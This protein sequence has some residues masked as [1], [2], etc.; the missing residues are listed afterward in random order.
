M[1]KIFASIFFLLLPVFLTGCQPIN[2]EGSFFASTFINPFSW[3]IHILADFTGGSFGIAIIS[4]TLLIR[5]ILMPL[6]MKQYNNQ[7]H[8]KEK[9][10]ALKPEMDQIQKKLKG[11]RD[12]AEQKKLQQEMFGLYQ[13]HGVNPL[14]GGCLPLLIQMPILMGLYDA[15]SGSSEIASHS[16]LWFS[17]GHPDI[18]IT[19]SAGF[20][21]Y[22][23]F[24]VSQSTMTEEQRKQMKFMGILSPVMI[25]M[26]SL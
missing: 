1:K 14:S 4:I 25:V 7:K 20:I 24:K 6:T 17:L 5:L 26:F 12:P 16:F 15:I 21:Y 23:Q 8:T 2:S 19:A 22:L 13:K 10:E 18:W 9:M 3:L 11:I